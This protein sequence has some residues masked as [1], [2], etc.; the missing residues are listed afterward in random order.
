MHIIKAIHGSRLKKWVFNVS[1][2]SKKLKAKR[3]LSCFSY[4]SADLSVFFCKE[5]ISEAVK[6]GG[7]RRSQV[8]SC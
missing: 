1:L 5:P 6:G 7:P 2:S 3:L 4:V 8:P